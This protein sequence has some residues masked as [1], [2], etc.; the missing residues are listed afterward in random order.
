[1]ADFFTDVVERPQD[2]PQRQALGRRAEVQRHLRTATRQASS[3]E[4]TLED[5]RDGLALEGL[6]EAEREADEA[7][8][9]AHEIEEK[10]EDI[11]DVVEPEEREFAFQERENPHK[12]D[13]AAELPADDLA[14]WLIEM[15][16]PG[17]IV[18]DEETARIG[19][20][21][22]IQLDRGELCF[23]KGII[24]ALDEGQKAQYCIEKVYKEASPARLRRIAAF[25][26]ASQV[27][28]METAQLPEGERL[29]PR[30]K[31]M[32]RELRKRG[33]ELA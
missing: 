4:E 2:P 16:H 22:C 3:L 17:G 30:L 13:E 7:L 1:V 32:E 24:G 25:K 18:V 5:L 15:E 10:L 27:C 8:S 14:T 11:A 29:A 20:C 26:E 21:Q 31:C 12:K 19:P 28:S 33:V 23:H 9:L 6:L